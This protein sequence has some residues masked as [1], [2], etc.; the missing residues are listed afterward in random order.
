MASTWYKT[1]GQPVF[2]PH[3]DPTGPCTL[4]EL[5]VAQPHRAAISWPEG[6][7][8]GIAHRLDTPT[9]GALLLA[10]DPG[11]L[12]ALRAAFSAGVFR[13]TY[14][15]EAART[16][17]WRSNVIDRP[18]AH[19]LKRANRMVVQRG[20][21]TPHRGKWYPAYTEL[22]W[23]HDRVWQAVITTGVTHQIRV[24]AAFVGLPLAGDTLYGGGPALV[25]EAFR[26]HHLGLEGGG[27]RTEPVPTPG[28]ATSL[29]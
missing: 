18:V 13:K 19:D 20:P 3:H 9:S 5:V 21:S 2:P 28:W 22:T 12:A 10:D 23:I 15:F 14:L 7:S 25:P 11:E 29:F 6:F 17:S 16:V 8:G 1:A 27:W 4:A 26:L 24:H